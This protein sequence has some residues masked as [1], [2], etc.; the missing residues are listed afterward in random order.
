[1]IQRINAKGDA[2]A[3]FTKIEV[4]RQ[5]QSCVVELPALDELTPAQLDEVSGGCLYGHGLVGPTLVLAVLV[6][7][8]VG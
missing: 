6:A 3:M 4:A 2:A 1:M 5:E 8:L 7:V